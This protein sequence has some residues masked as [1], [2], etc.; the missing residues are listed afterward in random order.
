MSCLL[1]GLSRQN[2][3]NSVETLNT[4]VFFIKKDVCTSKNGKIFRSDREEDHLLKL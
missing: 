3:P 1:D 4:L 2:W